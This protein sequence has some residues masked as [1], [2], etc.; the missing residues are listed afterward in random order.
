MRGVSAAQP[1]PLVSGRQPLTTL[2]ER[3]LC[4]L[5]TS[6]MCCPHLTRRLERRLAAGL[7]PMLTCS[8][9]MRSAAAV[10]PTCKAAHITAVPSAAVTVWLLC[11]TKPFR[12][13]TGHAVPAVWRAP[14]LA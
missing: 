14:L 8:C 5:K 9:A 12:Y 13:D 2:T 11:T 3:A 7:A 1:L 4:A 10:T 6:R